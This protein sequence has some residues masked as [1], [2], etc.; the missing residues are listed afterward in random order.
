M[1]KTYLFSGVLFAAMITGLFVVSN[2]ARE[3]ATVLAHENSLTSDDSE[4][5]ASY[6][7]VP[8]EVPPSP[9]ED[10]E[11]QLE[12]EVETEDAKAKEEKAISTPPPTALPTPKPT[13]KPT[14]VPVPTPI[15]I[16]MAEVTQHNSKDSCWTAINGSVYDVTSYIYKHPG[17][18]SRI[19]ALCGKDGSKAF[20][21]QH[22]G[23][24]RPEA[25]LASLKINT[26]IP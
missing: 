5:L 16:T 12:K 22:E 3:G 21:G 18:P 25:K 23:D 9:P 15:G 19:L 6:N 2:N 8:D 7:P 14:P 1:F 26:L 17:G 13:P 20:E 4:T 10:L 24:A 11:E